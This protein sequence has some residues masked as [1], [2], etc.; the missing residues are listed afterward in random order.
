M[1][2]FDAVDCEEYVLLGCNAV[3]FGDD[4]TFRMKLSPPSSGSKSK[5]RKK[6]AEGGLP[7]LFSSTQ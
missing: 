2:S 3:W 4:Q 1:L 7:K 5:P 6:V